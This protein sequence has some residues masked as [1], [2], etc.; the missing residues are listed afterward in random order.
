MTKLCSGVIIR[1]VEGEERG[2]GEAEGEREESR[3]EERLVGS[4]DLK[5][6]INERET[7]KKKYNNK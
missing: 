2:E 3:R 6:R 1:I 7:D 5:E 4:C